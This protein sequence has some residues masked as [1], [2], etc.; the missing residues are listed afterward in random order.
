MNDEKWK[1]FILALL[2][3]S[4]GALVG[5]S[6]NLGRIADHLLKSDYINEWLVARGHSLNR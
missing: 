6:L 4:T 3:L 2:A 1:L 5:I